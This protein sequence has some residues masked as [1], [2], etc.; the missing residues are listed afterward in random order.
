MAKNKMSEVAKLLGIELEE[1]FRL[2]GYKL[3]YKL[4][5]NGLMYWSNTLQHWVLSNEIGKLL[6]GEFKIIKLPKPILDDVEREYLGNIIKPFRDRVI[7]IAKAETVKTYS[8]NAKVY[9]CIYIMYKD[10]SKKKNPYYMGFPCFKKGTMYKGMILDKG[11]T[12]E[13]L[14]L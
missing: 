13:E 9:E 14:G 10:S 1:E 2:N 8:P 6:S 4:S 5:N 3:K 11:Y 7:Y 12:L